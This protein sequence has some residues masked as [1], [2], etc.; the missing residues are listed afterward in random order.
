MFGY[1]ASKWMHDLAVQGDALKLPDGGVV[2]TGVQII[3]ASNVDEF[4]KNLN[5]MKAGG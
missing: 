2:D 3:D 4:E 5:A 1:L